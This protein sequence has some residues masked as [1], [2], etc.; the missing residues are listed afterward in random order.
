MS[1]Q[2][3][4]STISRFLDKIENPKILEIGVDMGQSTI[5]LISNMIRSNRDFIYTGVEILSPTQSKR[6]D[7]CIQ[8]LV[9]MEG[10]R[11]FGIDVDNMNDSNVRMVYQDSLSALPL[12]VSYGLKFDLILI[13]GDHN[14]ETVSKE[15]SYIDE[16]SYPGTI[17]II[18]DYSGRHEGSDMF[19]GERESHTEVR[20][21][22]MKRQDDPKGGGTSGAVNDFIKLS[23]EKWGLFQGSAEL[24]GKVFST[25]F[26][27]MFQN[28]HYKNFCINKG[29]R[30]AL[31][32]EEI[33]THISIDAL[34]RFRQ[35]FIDEVTQ[36]SVD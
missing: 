36:S 11:L 18:D 6:V 29:Y 24:R 1:Y 21:D 10:V 25:D 17:V 19:Y 4:I 7:H 28:D 33:N 32:Y 5:P 12:M 23:N 20:E 15:L 35:S 13:D 31:S 16:L 8:Q 22:I 27:Y 14:Y 30:S 3:T 34:R 2:G 9:Q 26:V